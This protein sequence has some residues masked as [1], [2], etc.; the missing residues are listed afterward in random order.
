MQKIK[1]GLCWAVILSFTLLLAN[2]SCAIYGNQLQATNSSLTI[3]SQ[4]ISKLASDME[5]RQK[6]ETQFKRG[7]VYLSYSEDRGVMYIGGSF[8]SMPHELLLSSPTKIQDQVASAEKE[9]KKWFQ[10]RGVLLEVTQPKL[11]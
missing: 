3:N 2:C 8:C 6:S 11:D 4:Q 10:S 9:V 7:D 5:F 1:H